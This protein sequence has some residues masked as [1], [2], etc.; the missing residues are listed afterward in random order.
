MSFINAI[1]TSCWHPI[2]EIRQL[3]GN[4]LFIPQLFSPTY[5]GDQ[6]LI[7]TGQFNFQFG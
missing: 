2:V 3:F 1:A 7:T 6:L 4:R 5:G